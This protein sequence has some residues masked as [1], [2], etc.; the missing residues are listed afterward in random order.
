MIRTALVFGGAY[1]LGSFGGEKIATALKIDTAG[2]RT[3]VKI[4]TGVIAFGL[5]SMVLR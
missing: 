4:G 2:V 3:G 1:A 5:L